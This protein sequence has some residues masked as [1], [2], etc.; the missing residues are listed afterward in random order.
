[1]ANIFLGAK[2]AAAIFASGLYLVYFWL[3]R[4]Y[5]KRQLA[6]PFLAAFFIAAPF[7]S[8]LSRPRPMILMI[9]LMLLFVHFLIQRNWRALILITVVYSLT[10]VS[11]PF[12]L[13][14][15][16]ICESVRYIDEKKWEIKTLLATAAGVII[17]ILIHPHFPNN[18]LVFYLNAVLVP[19]YAMK[20]GLE[21]GAE[22]FPIST[23]DFVLGY[24]FI[25]I[26]LIVLAAL[27]TSSGVKIKTATKIWMSI[28]GFF[29]VFAFF[30]Q[31]YITHAYPLILIA[32]AA[33]ISDWWDSRGQALGVRQYKN[34][35]NWA[36]ILIVGGGFAVTGL[37]T[38]KAFR[39]SA[40][41]EMYYNLHYE[42]ISKWMSA[43]IPPGELIFHTNWSDGQ[44]FI[45]MNPQDD[46]FVVLDPMY[47]YYRDTKQY[48][49]YRDVAFGRAKDPYAVLKNDFGVRYGYA[50]KNYF[51]GLIT[52]IRPDARFEILAE[53]G[54]GLVFR[55]R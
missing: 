50:G 36:L 28:A 47:M 35:A 12:L 49:L 16:F 34:L 29:F 48:K 26:G 31:R 52:Q 27:A 11:G 21:L 53:D 46:Y 39:E 17:G 43:N 51:S 44:Y 42:R 55:L 20:W 40:R 30:S 38:Y 2:I 4:R 8:A 15:A 37:Y 22:F 25:L 1:M 9:A 14:F 23:R 41:S 13:L 10:H 3:L 32:V 7:L 24:P 5:S 19:L 45:G 6:V 54:M 33:Y 18:L